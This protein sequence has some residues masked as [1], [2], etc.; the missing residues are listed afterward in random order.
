MEGLLDGDGSVRVSP[1]GESVE[2]FGIS[3][4]IP[5]FNEEKRIGAAVGSVREAFRSCGVERYEVVVCD[6]NSTD[7]TGKLAEEAGAKV[8]FEAHNQIA[9]ARNSGAA[10]ARGE[11]LI[12]MDADSRLSAELL[13]ETLA[14]I[15]SGK[16]GGGGATVAFDRGDLPWHVTV[17]LGIWNRISRSMNW[18]AG[19]YVFCL[20]EAWA[21]TGGF[22]E[23][24]YA[25]EE[26]P[27][28]A[29]LKKWCRKRGLRFRVI[30]APPL[31]TSARKVENYGMWRLLRMVF[32]LAMPGALGRRESCGYWYQRPE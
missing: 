23:E 28:S 4:V 26:I 7:A 30:G 11:W 2:K 20:R 10:A 29:A 6:N 21:E 12:F 5:A 9:R 31:V 18:A 22:C 14:R 16:T 17:G 25:G 13:A 27:F 1:M 8:I 3:V 15:E 19:S 32:S 24:R